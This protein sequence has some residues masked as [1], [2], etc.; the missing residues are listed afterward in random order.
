MGMGV[1][2]SQV[3]NWLAGSRS[4]LLGGSV[5]GTECTAQRTEAATREVQLSPKSTEVG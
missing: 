1:V 3:G 5:V 4:N 2:R